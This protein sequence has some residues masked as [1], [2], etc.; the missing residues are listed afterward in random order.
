MI[1]KKILLTLFVVFSL[2]IVSVAAPKAGDSAPSFTATDSNGKSHS[3][4]DFKGKYVVLEWTNSGCPFTIKHYVSGN[5]QKL[6]KEWTSKGVVWLTVLSSAPGLQ[7]YKTASEE[8]AYLKQVNASPTAVLMDPKG[9]L[10]HLYGAKTTPHMFVIDPSGK[11]IYDGAID[12][13]ATT[14]QEDIAEAKNYVQAA[15][16]EALSGKPVTTASSQPYGCSVKYAK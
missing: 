16:S 11:V 8:N 7:G 1:I 14:D 10:G 6:Q 2:A 9:D 3:L 4:S 5:M 12:D 15:L 13:R